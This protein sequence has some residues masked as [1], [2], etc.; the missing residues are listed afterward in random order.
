MANLAGL[1]STYQPLVLGGVTFYQFEVPE[2]IPN[3]FGT[4]KLAIHDFAGGDRTVQQLGAFPFPDISWTGEF[5]QGDTQN[6][7]SSPVQ[8]ASQLNTFRV[9]AQP[10]DLVWGPFQYSVIVAEFE[11]I[12]KLQQ[13]LRYRIKVIPLVDNTT[14]SNQAS[15]PPNTTQILGNSAT[16]V[17]AATVT[18]VGLLVPAALRFVAAQISLAVTAA[19]IQANG[20][21]QGITST[22]QASL[23]AQIS[24]LQLS[25]QPTINGSDYGAA[26]GA[27]ILS[28]SL[29]TL[30]TVLNSSN[31]VAPLTTLTVTNPNLY[32]LAAQ[33]YSDNTLWPLIAQ[34]NNF[35]DAFPIGTFTIVIPSTSI[36]SPLIP[37]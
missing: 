36:Q 13:E 7:T 14:T 26:S 23:Q 17:T 18:P 21:A 11:I 24:A 35:Q 34:Q 1:G 12:G 20:S 19:I 6:G 37:S 5:F 30:S 3:L 25:L 4:Q 8:R 9:M 33:Y 2:E 32:Q 31:V 28:A 27:T 29:S 10:V 16:G 22:T 15:S